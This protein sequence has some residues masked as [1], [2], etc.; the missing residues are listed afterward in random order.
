MSRIVGYVT[1]IGYFENFQNNSLKFFL[2]SQ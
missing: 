2:I 1:N